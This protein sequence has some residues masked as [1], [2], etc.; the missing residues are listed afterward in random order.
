V[1][2][3]TAYVKKIIDVLMKS[4]R[5]KSSIFFF[6]FDEFGGYDHVP[7]VKTVSP[8]GIKP[9]LRLNDVCNN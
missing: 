3:G 6:S 1:Q 2:K 5:W 4:T 7:P 9:M 8:D